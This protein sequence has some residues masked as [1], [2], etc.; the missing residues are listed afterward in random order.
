MNMTKPIEPFNFKGNLG[1]GDNSVAVGFQAHVDRRGEL[2]IDFEDLS[3]TEETRFILTEWHKEGS[4]ITYF[5]LSGEAE[6]NVS[7]D[8]DR[9]YFN[10]IGPH[11]DSKRGSCFVFDAACEMATL[12]RKA[13]SPSP[14]PV[15]LLALLAFQCFP[16]VTATCPLGELVA[17]GDV[18]EADLQNAIGYIQL[19]AHERPA[20]LAQ[21]RAEAKQLLDH[22]RRVMSFASGVNLADP[23][24]TFFL[25]DDVEIS[26]Q[27]HMS[28]RVSP[29]PA[30]P[31]VGRDDIFSAAVTSFFAPPFDAKNLWMALEWIAMEATHNEVRLVNAMTA[32][33]NLVS[34]NTRDSRELLDDTPFTKLKS[35]LTRTIKDFADNND[36][37][38]L[39]PTLVDE[40][41]AKLA[42]LQRRSLRRKLDIL[43][44]SWSVPMEGITKAMIRG[45]F[46][47]RN[48]II[49]EGRYYVE[50]QIRPELWDHYCVIREIVTRLIFS[51][52]GFRGRYISHLGGYS[53]TS[54]P[55]H[56]R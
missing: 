17:G 49:H 25:D 11:S 34:S 5:S 29:I 33:E 37:Q 10:S 50:G 9:L 6:D 4:R 23:T 12:R 40:M 55:P 36:F 31:I 8:T 20:D 32:L 3:L 45:A 39:H 2:V 7:L 47:A 13:T 44:E 22:V 19:R 51:A 43:L 21:W 38:T 46:N 41:T 24:R 1:L 53:Q 52:I 16:Q 56:A 15:Y 28:F 35:A 26:V 18:R 14:T 42:E 48:E 27:P 54:F 30:F